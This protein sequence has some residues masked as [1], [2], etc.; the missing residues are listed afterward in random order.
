MEIDADDLEDALQPISQVAASTSTLDAATKVL[1]EPEGRDTLKLTATDLDVTAVAEAP[2]RIDGDP[3]VAVDCSHLYQL[4][5]QL[6]G[7]LTVEVEDNNW[8]RVTADDHDVNARVSGIHPDAYPD[9]P[10][11]DAGDLS[12]PS[13][14]LEVMVERTAHAVATDDARE[15]LTGAYLHITN[16]DKLRAEATDGHRLARHT[17]PI[18]FDDGATTQRLREG[19]LVPLK[20]WEQIGRLAGDHETITLGY[21]ESGGEGSDQIV[22][23]AGTN[24]LYARPIVGTFPDADQVL[25]DKD[26][27][28]AC[29]DRTD[30]ID[31]LRFVSMFASNKTN[32]VRLTL[33]DGEL[34]LYASDP[35]RGE[36]TQGVPVD[37]GD[38]SEEAT[39][40][41]Y[42]YRYLLDA[43]RA[44]DGNE[45]KLHIIDTLSPTTIKPAGD[46]ETVHVIMPMRLG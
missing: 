2:A 14:V 24:T 32:N 27:Q 3:A 16:A 28:P 20:A 5:G 19:I 22:V 37:G 43:L 31:A 45:A 23:Q 25:P 7:T 36:A 38:E 30:L 26:A 46:A 1:L 44:M 18:A 33:D 34:Q 39:K 13:E 12:V 10:G 8:M 15:N 21:A 35:E 9:T 42:N 11:A 29:I 41:G 40:A 17:A 6:D 4:V